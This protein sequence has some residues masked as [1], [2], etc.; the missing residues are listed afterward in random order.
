MRIDRRNDPLPM[1]QRIF[2]PGGIATR[3]PLF[4]RFVMAGVAAGAE[5]CYDRD[6]TFG[7]QNNFCT[8]GLLISS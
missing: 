5:E 3:Q 8:A 6:N 4:G 7:D 1:A 2:V